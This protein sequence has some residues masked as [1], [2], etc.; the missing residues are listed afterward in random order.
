MPSIRARLLVT[1]LLIFTLTWLLLVILTFFESRHEIEELFDAQLAQS[2]AVLS[3]LT[4]HD[5]NELKR[6]PTPQLEKAEYGHA[7]QKKI[8]FQIWSGN[9]LILSSA[10]APLEPMTSKDGYTDQKINQQDWRVFSLPHA[11]FRITVAERY[12]VRNEL[13]Y[14][15]TL[16]A[17]Y[18][19]ILVLPILAV[20]IWFAIGRNMRPLNRIAME[21]ASRTP[22]KLQSVIINNHIPLEITPLINSLNQ[23]LERLRWAFERERRFTADASHELRTPLASLKIQAQVALRSGNETEHRHALN[24]IITGVDR[25]THLVEQL[26]TLARLDPDVSEIDKTPVDLRKILTEIISELHLDAEKKQVTL[27]LKDN[28]QGTISGYSAALTILARN[29]IDNALRYTPSGGRVDIDVHTIGNSTQLTVTDNGPGIPESEQQNVFNRFYRMDRESETGCGLG[30]SIVHRI[31]E[32]HNAN[33]EL[34][35]SPAGKGLQVT[36]TFPLA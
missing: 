10:S 34:S 8:S 5:I 24:Q 29:L 28:A 9:Q 19:L 31:A 35:T 3:E 22:E 21:V 30:L 12:D 18:P 13:I 15:I 16:D 11:N 26:L 6:N 27:N 36:V 32:L 33:V 7:Y 17:L 1:L 23:L 4:H 20:L 14:N 2:A 25:A